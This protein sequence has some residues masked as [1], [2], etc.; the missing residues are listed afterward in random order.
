VKPEKKKKE[1]YDYSGK[2]NVNWL[3]I[4]YDLTFETFTM[5]FVKPHEKMSLQKPW[6][7]TS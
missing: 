1:G 3:I 5:A 2:L 4:T 7:G 6:R